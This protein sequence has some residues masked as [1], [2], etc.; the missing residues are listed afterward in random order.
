MQGISS[1]KTCEDC[2]NY[3]N[4]IKLKAETNNKQLLDEVFVMCGIIK[5]GVSVI[6]RAEGEADI[7]LIPRPSANH[8]NRIQ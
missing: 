5:V 1:L 8:K 6:S 3:D 7:T 2:M 4:I